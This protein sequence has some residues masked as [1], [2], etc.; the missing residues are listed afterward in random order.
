MT[1]PLI[2]LRDWRKR[3]DLYLD[4]IEGT[5]FQWGAMDCG[6]FAAGA[7]HAMTGVDLAAD[8]RGKYKDEAGAEATVKA[9]GFDDFISLV[10]S[11]VP[12]GRLGDAVIGDLVTVEGIYGNAALGIVG[13][14]H[15]TCMTLRGKSAVPLAKA[16]RV[17]KVG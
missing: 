17:F 3:L 2:R 5:P 9:A 11:R 15:V 6:L 1:E 13:G 8:V 14:S 16:S 12:A 10:A 4:S 7:I